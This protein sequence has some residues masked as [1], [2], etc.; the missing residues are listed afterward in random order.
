MR[1]IRIGSQHKQLP[2]RWHMRCRAT[3]V[4]PVPDYARLADRS[5]LI[6]YMSLLDEDYTECCGRESDRNAA[7][8]M[9]CRCGEDMDL[10]A[11]QL[12]GADGELVA[13]RPFALCPMC[14]WWIEF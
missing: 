6:E 5:W 13:Y 4:S 7:R 8:H 2:N 11:F 10:R 3:A 9:N 1:S 14:R 12:V